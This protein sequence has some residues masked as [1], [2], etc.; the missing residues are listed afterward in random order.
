MLQGADGVALD[1]RL[2]RRARPQ[3]NAE[4]FFDL[5]NNLRNNGLELSKMPLVIQFNKRDLPEIRSEEELTELAAR[6]KEPVFLA[7]ATRGI[8]VVETFIGLLHLTWQTLIAPTTSRR[9]SRLTAT[10]SSATP[11]TSSASRRRLAISLASR[12][13]GARAVHAAPPQSRKAR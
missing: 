10:C 3:H 13:G 4:A 12:V 5:R 11:R 9:S 1:R 6:G 2:A 7:I 8:G